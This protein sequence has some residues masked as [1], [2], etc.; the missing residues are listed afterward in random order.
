MDAR[1]KIGAFRDRL[2]I[3]GHP[4]SSS[5]GSM[6]PGTFAGP[7][8]AL[9]SGRD[10]GRSSSAGAGEE[11]Y[12]PEEY[13]P[14]VYGNF[15]AQFED[16]LPPYLRLYLGGRQQGVPS[17]RSAPASVSSVVTDRPAP[18]PALPWTP[19]HQAPFPPPPGTCDPSTL[20]SSPAVAAPMN[21]SDWELLT[22]A[23]VW[24]EDEED[25][26]L[27]NSFA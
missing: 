13:S 4:R 11:E 5:R 12:S 15:V 3:S 19:R 16:D 2:G 9:I 10:Q 25:Y 24:Q 14:E 1:D 17:L 26:D 22:T 18:V 6:P 8:N 21:T 23:G 7:P 27:Q 20:T